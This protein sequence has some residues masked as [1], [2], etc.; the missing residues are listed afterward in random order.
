MTEQMKLEFIKAFAYGKTNEEVTDVTGL[1]L[2]EAK[3]F[4]VKNE[5]AI[6]EKMMELKE[7]GYI[8]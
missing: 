8:G 6:L 7:V 1:S 5:D 3:A 2:D 4:E